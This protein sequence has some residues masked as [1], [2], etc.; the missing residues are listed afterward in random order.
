MSRT[1]GAVL[2]GLGTA[3][4]LVALALAGGA[5]G[6]AL[7]G[8]VVFL[9]SL[10]LAWLLGGVRSA[11]DGTPPIASLLHRRPAR[12]GRVQQLEILARQLAAG[13]SSAFELHRR[14]RPLVREIAAARLARHHGVDLD[15]LPDRARELLGP[16]SWELAR[17]DREPPQERFARGWAADEIAGLVDE[18]ERI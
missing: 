3:A 14:L 8:Y 6:L 11:A 12:D 17:P 2:A 10:G 7:Y 1:R 18:L 13:Q 5:R 9:G 16:R 15:R 4:L